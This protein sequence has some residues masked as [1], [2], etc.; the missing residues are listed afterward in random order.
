MR[1]DKK[2]GKKNKKQAGKEKRQY[3]SPKGFARGL[4]TAFAESSYGILVLVLILSCF[5][6]LMV[7]SAGYYQTVNMAEPDPFYYLK[8]QGFFVLSGL[9]LLAWAACFDYH[10]YKKYAN[11]III[12]SIALLV[13]VM[14]IGTGANGAQRWISIGP[15]NIT[16]SELSK[17]AVII[18]TSVYVYEDPDR[19]KTANKGLWILFAIMGV[20][21][22]LIIKQP[23]LSTAIVICAIMVGIMFLAGLSWGWIGFFVGS[24]VA[25]T[26]A[27]ITFGKNTHWYSRIMSFTDPFAD[28]QGDGYQVCQSLIAL[29]N[30]G[31]TGLGPGNSITKNL[32]L[33]EPQNDFILAIIGEEL[34]YLGFLILMV[35]YILL[36]FMC[37]MT[38]AKAADKLG[39]YI[40]AGVSIMLGLQVAINVAVVTSSMPATGITLPFVSYGGSS[41]WVFMFAMG[42]VLNISRTRK[43]KKGKVAA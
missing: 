12:A 41:M 27:I 38:A 11:L 5:G 23:N 20:H 3:S 25:G 43:K 18:F 40:A 1:K 42:I 10:K 22:L 21:A 33:P 28:A 8:R 7:F 2:E 24:L 9:A 14:L 36:L 26:F 35:V 37:I 13:L 29:G 19:I 16:P 17:L 32:Y 34:G 4:A 31:L 15:I 39:F 6:V 30:G